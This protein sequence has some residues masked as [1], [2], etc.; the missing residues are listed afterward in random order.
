M[1][2]Q[3]FKSTKGSYDLLRSRIQDFREFY[4]PDYLI[5]VSYHYWNGDVI[6][7][8]EIIQEE[9]EEILQYDPDLTQ[10]ELSEEAILNV[11]Y[12]LE[13]SRSHYKPAIADVHKAIKCQLMPFYLY[14]EL[15]LATGEIERDLTPRFDAYQMLTI[16]TVPEGSWLFSDREYFEK[17]VGQK[18]TEEA[19]ESCLQFSKIKQLK[20]TTP[21]RSPPLKKYEVH[22]P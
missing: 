6:L 12:D 21:A 9:K 8:E 16:N 14:N 10:D 1:G 18:V 15:Y 7:P 3:Q 4:D 13:S 22:E 2:A 17:I 5:D 11:L 20:K 19:I